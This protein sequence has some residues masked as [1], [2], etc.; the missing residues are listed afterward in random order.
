MLS[1]SSRDVL[2]DIWDL[3]ESVSKGFF[4]LLVGLLSAK[5]ESSAHNFVGA[6]VCATFKNIDRLLSVE[7]FFSR[8]YLINR[9][10]HG[11]FVITDPIVRHYRSNS[12]ALFP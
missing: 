5:P 8:I 9:S 7:L 11:C 10:Y 3:I 12:S 6:L 1:S 2:D 4:W